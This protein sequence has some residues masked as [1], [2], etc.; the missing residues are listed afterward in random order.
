MLERLPTKHHIDLGAMRLLIAEEGEN[1]A[2]ADLPRF[3]MPMAD[4]TLYIRGEEVA[5]FEL[6]GVQRAPRRLGSLTSSMIED[7]CAKWERYLFS[8]WE[9]SKLSPL[10]EA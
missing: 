7:I 3:E 5:R 8:A 9:Y 10:M 2:Q 4:R 6:S 1:L